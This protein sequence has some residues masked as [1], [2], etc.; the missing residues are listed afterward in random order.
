MGV[1]GAPPV[2]DCCTTVKNFDGALGC[3]IGGK[4]QSL[5]N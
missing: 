1:S 5:K 3:V 2:T 4:R